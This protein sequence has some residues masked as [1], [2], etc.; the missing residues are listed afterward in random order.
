MF[1]A[2][3]WYISAIPGDGELIKPKNNFVKQEKMELEICNC[4]KWIPYS[5]MWVKN[6]I[7]F[8]FFTKVSISD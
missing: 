8:T 6:A 4:E 7:F 5:Q 2:Q 1:R 3:R